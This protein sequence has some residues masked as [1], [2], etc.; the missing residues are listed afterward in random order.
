M[1]WANEKRETLKS[2]C[3]SLSPG[4]YAMNDLSSGFSDRKKIPYPGRNKIF[5]NGSIV[6]SPN[7]WWILL[8]VSLLL[9]PSIYLTVIM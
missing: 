1:K 8:T 3:V 9:G 5:F 4:H 2:R 7:A 6:T